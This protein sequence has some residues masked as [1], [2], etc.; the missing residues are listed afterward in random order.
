MM[1]TNSNTAARKSCSITNNNNKTQENETLFLAAVF[2]FV[3]V[4]T[5]L[6]FSVYL[7]L[8]PSNLKATLSY[9]LV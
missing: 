2:E 7:C 4:I 8:E 3:Y 1:N 9:Y 6:V 5:A